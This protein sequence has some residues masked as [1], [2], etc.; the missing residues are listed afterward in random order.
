MLREGKYEHLDEIYFEGLSVGS[1]NMVGDETE[2]DSVYEDS[3]DFN[4]SFDEI[5]KGT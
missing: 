5:K 3:T 1:K 2:D 4:D